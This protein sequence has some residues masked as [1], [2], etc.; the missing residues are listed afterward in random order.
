MH[1]IYEPKLLDHDFL[2]VVLLSGLNGPIISVMIVCTFVRD[3]AVHFK[4]K[5]EFGGII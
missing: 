2:S 4:V 5:F 3:F 1:V